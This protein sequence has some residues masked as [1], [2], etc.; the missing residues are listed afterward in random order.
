M[1]STRKKA[2]VDLDGAIAQFGITD[3][4]GSAGYILA[5]GRMLDLS[6]AAE[7]GTPGIRAYDHRQVEPYVEGDF[8]HLSDA[9]KEFMRQTGAIRW[10]Y[11]GGDYALIDAETKPTSAQLRT[12]RYILEY[13]PLNGLTV[14][15]ATGVTEEEVFPDVRAVRRV[16]GFKDVEVGSA[17]STCRDS[18]SVG[19][20]LTPLVY[21]RLLEVGPEAA[22]RVLD[23]GAGRNAVHAEALRAEGFDVTAWDFGDNF[24][25]AVHDKRGLDRKYDTVVA[26]NVLNVQQSKSMLTETLDELASAVKPGGT[27][28]A[29]MPNAPRHHDIDPSKIESLLERAGFETQDREGGSAPVWT[30][31][32]KRKT[33]S[34]RVGA[35]DLVPYEQKPT[36][37]WEKAKSLVTR[38]PAEAHQPPQEIPGGRLWTSHWE[39][40][41]R[42]INNLHKGAK[43]QL[44]KAHADLGFLTAQVQSMSPAA[45][46]S[47]N[48]HRLYRMQ[49]EKNLAWGQEQ[50]K[51]SVDTARPTYRDYVSNQEF[52]LAELDEQKEEASWPEQRIEELGE[53]IAAEEARADRMAQVISA[54]EALEFKTSPGTRRRQYTY[55]RTGVEHDVAELGRFLATQDLVAAYGP[56]K[57]GYAQSDWEHAA[58]E[59]QAALKTLQDGLTEALSYGRAEPGGLTLS[60]PGEAGGVSMAEI[61]EGGLSPA[62]EAGTLTVTAGDLLDIGSPAG[63]FEVMAPVSVIVSSPF[64]SLASF[65]LELPAGLHFTTARTE[66]GFA[67][68]AP[69]V[70]PVTRIPPPHEEGWDVMSGWPSGTDSWATQEDEGWDTDPAKFFSDAPWKVSRLALLGLVKS[71]NVRRLIDQEGPDFG[72]W[73]QPPA[74]PLADEDTT[75]TTDNT[76]ADVIPLF[77][78]DAAADLTVPEIVGPMSAV[79][80]LAWPEKDNPDTYGRVGWVAVANGERAGYILL[81]DP[82]DAADGY[83]V[84]GVWVTPAYRGSGLSDQLYLTAMKWTRQQGLQPDYSVTP[85]SAGV[86][87]RLR[88]RPDV[89][90]IPVDRDGPFIGTDAREMAED[91]EVPDRKERWTKTM[92]PALFSKYRMVDAKVVVGAADLTLWGDRTLPPHLEA[93]KVRIQ[94]LSAEA[95]TLRERGLHDQAEEV[96]VELSTAMDLFERE[97]DDVEAPDNEGDVEDL[98]SGYWSGGSG[99]THRGPDAAT[100]D[101]AMLYKEHLDGSIH[102]RV[103]TE[104]DLVQIARHVIRDH[105]GDITRT[106]DQ[107]L[108]AAAKDA[109]ERMMQLRSR[110][111]ANEL[112]ITESLSSQVDTMKGLSQ[113]EQGVSDSGTMGDGAVS[114]GVDDV[115]GNPSQMAETSATET[116]YG[117]ITVTSSGGILV[118]AGDDPAVAAYDWQGHVIALEAVGG[119]VR[120]PEGPHPTVIP[121]NW[122][123]YGYFSGLPAEDGDSLDIVVGPD[124]NMDTVFIAV[125]KDPPPRQARTAAAA[126]A[127]GTDIQI[128]QGT[129]W[130]EAVDEYRNANIDHDHVDTSSADQGHLDGEGDAF[131][132]NVEEAIAEWIDE[133][134]A[135]REPADPKLFNSGINLP[136]EWYEVVSNGDDDTLRARLVGAGMLDADISELFGHVASTVDSDDLWQAIQMV[137][138]DS[139]FVDAYWLTEHSDYGDPEYIY[140]WARGDDAVEELKRQIEARKGGMIFNWYVSSSNWDDARTSH[141][142]DEYENYIGTYHTP[143]GSP[144]PG[145]HTRLAEEV[146]GKLIPDAEDIF[147]AKDGDE[148]GVGQYGYGARH[149]FGPMR[150]AFDYAEEL[151]GEHGYQQVFFNEY[152]AD[153]D[154]EWKHLDDTDSFDARE[155]WERLEH[156]DTYT[157]DDDEDED[158]DDD[159]APVDEVPD[160]VTVGADDLVESWDTDLDAKLTDAAQAWASWSLTGN[161]T[162]VQAFLPLID[163]LE[164]EM[165]ERFSLWQQEVETI[166]NQL[167]AG[168]PPPQMPSPFRSIEQDYGPD[169]VDDFTQPLRPNQYRPA[170]KHAQATYDPQVGDIVTWPKLRKPIKL[171]SLRPDGRFEAH[172]LKNDAPTTMSREAVINNVMKGGWTVERDGKPYWPPSAPTRDESYPEDP[173]D[174]PMCRAFGPSVSRH[175]MNRAHPKFARRASTGFRQFKPMVGFAD[176][177]AAEAG[178]K[179]MWPS[180]MFGGIHEVSAEQFLELVLPKVI[181]ASFDVVAR[182]Y[183]QVVHK[184]RMVPRMEWAL[185]SP[186]SNRPIKW[187]GET[188]P[189]GQQAL[190]DL[191]AYLEKQQKKEDRELRRQE[192]LPSD[193]Q[194]W[195][196]LLEDSGLDVNGT[197]MGEAQY[198]QWQAEMKD[199]RKA[200]SDFLKQWKQQPAYR[201][202][203]KALA[204]WMLADAATRG[205]KPTRPRAP[206]PS[207]PPQRPVSTNAAYT[208]INDRLG[209]NPALGTGVSSPLHAFSETLRAEGIKTWSQLDEAIKSDRFADLLGILAPTWRQEES[210]D[211]QD[212]VDAQFVLPPDVQEILETGIL[213]DQ[214]RELD[215]RHEREWNDLAEYGQSG[216]FDGDVSYPK[217]PDLPLPLPEP[218]IYV[219]QPDESAEAHAERMKLYRQ[220]QERADAAEGGAVLEYDIALPDSDEFKT[221]EEHQRSG[222]GRGRGRRIAQSAPTIPGGELFIEQSDVDDFEV[223]ESLWGTG[224]YPNAGP[225]Y[226]PSTSASASRTTGDRTLAEALDSARKINPALTE[227]WVC[228]TDRGGEE[229]SKHRVSQ[230]ATKTEAPAANAGS[231]RDCPICAVLPGHRRMHKDGIFRLAVVT[232]V[233]P[234]APEGPGLSWPNPADGEQGAGDQSAGDGVYRDQILLVTTNDLK[235]QIEELKGQ[236]G[237]LEANGQG[238][239]TDTSG[240]DVTVGVGDLAPV[241]G[242]PGTVRVGIADV[243]GLTPQEVESIKQAL[244]QWRDNAPRG[245]E[246]PGEMALARPEALRA[247]MPEALATLG[248]LAQKAIAQPLDVLM[249]LMPKSAAGRRR[250]RKQIKKKKR[251]FR[252]TWRMREGSYVAFSA[253]YGEGREVSL[254]PNSRILRISEDTLR[255]SAG[256]KVAAQDVELVA[257]VTAQAE[258]IKNL[259]VMLDRLMA[260]N[261]SG[262]DAVETEDRLIVLNPAAL[263]K[264][265]P[266]QRWLQ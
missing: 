196:M 30:M 214:R 99:I 203:E 41:N 190:A 9:M 98:G 165:P 223:L 197:N 34:I 182:S 125:Q 72:D 232:N 240:G 160:A 141:T 157:Y 263:E 176:A 158:E 39:R 243:A 229:W 102:G 58:S 4:P 2:A 129:Y 233:L 43:E 132:E 56:G 88:R 3:D 254:R 64:A 142:S 126:T 224:G 51:N 59:T 97:A 11:M 42:L 124:D 251:F 147:I 148:W 184:K 198:A 52:L 193:A 122:V 226:P 212:Y 37:L 228:R 222:R 71:P 185:L 201:A 218:G 216:A 253:A 137:A 252:P 188:Q 78:R 44:R 166:K 220:K 76:D 46:D 33:A 73:K 171:L 168:Q 101:L 195:R 241:E 245:A 179:L 116:P 235:Q 19:G 40:A 136:D 103:D 262:Y 186:D 151:A 93:L 204:Q 231:W 139:S 91:A 115:L 181:V 178:F 259:T 170:S 66:D 150:D 12:I 189:S 162:A 32:K 13:L 256:A 67:L 18:G 7:G 134:P 69:G 192:A 26:S 5:D 242:A 82:E 144:F 130:E 50:L 159:E 156:H 135:A 180:A 107:E 257:A 172:D 258:S 92:N 123:G 208:E 45:A 206:A 155:H 199:Y 57:A 174:C 118:R 6:G 75:D 60:E 128:T 16:L 53:E 119:D 77:G 117:S 163:E 187:Y 221:Y 152:G 55:D 183:P 202:Y 80:A 133:D 113:S 62:D 247:L 22:G 104:E 261:K 68:T 213:E 237:E 54:I 31:T 143:R 29:N 38:S 219:Q 120:F 207:P 24:N 112:D 260:V 21:Q 250:R 111:A 140:A 85:G 205:R 177:A 49:V 173:R 127:A 14:S 217:S 81:K 17:N 28:I 47:K 96:E 109:Y 36:S 121:S 25:K 83:P 200:R 175:H 20:P 61:G 79:D 114:V 90:A 105:G 227:I 27:L 146:E 15:N 110:S 236:V 246:E 108:I 265:P 1:S 70:W 210:Y 154:D 234:V 225:G 65:E 94:T 87:H 23:Y 167:R 255:K 215:E 63:D 10:S 230:G 249:A 238:T 209:L 169:D 266:R 244:M 48:R 164:R 264:Q 191:T 131:I 149:N 86:Y 8:D 239:G 145:W 106:S 153:D 161:A 138:W 194:L 248:P 35:S 74:D 211:Q 84:L 95:D 100:W 89:S